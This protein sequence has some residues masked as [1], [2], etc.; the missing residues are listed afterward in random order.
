MVIK[1]SNYICLDA[2]GI[3][4]DSFIFDQVDNYP[5]DLVIDLDILK[6]H[7]TNCEECKTKLSAL[8][9]DFNVILPK[10][11]FSFK[12]GLLKKRK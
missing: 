2:I 12:S 7:I 8:A 10:L 4:S 1:L 6:E 9:K 5:E 11:L 3:L